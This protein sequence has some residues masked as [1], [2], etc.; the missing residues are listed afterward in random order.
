MSVDECERCGVKC[1]LIEHNERLQARAEGAT[2]L[3]VVNPMS[4]PDGVIKRIF[5]PD[6]CAKVGALARELF[7]SHDT[8][9][10][11]FIC[12]SFAADD[13]PDLRGFDGFE[14][15]QGQYQ[16]D[17][18]GSSS[19]ILYAKQVAKLGHI[20]PALPH[21]I[22]R[23]AGLMPFDTVV[24]HH[25][26]L[27]Q[28]QDNP[29]VVFDWHNDTAQE[30]DDTDRGSGKALLTVIHFVFCSTD[31]EGSAVQV[32]GKDPVVYSDVGDTMIFAAH[33]VHKSVAPVRGRCIKLAT[34]YTQKETLPVCLLQDRTSRFA[35]V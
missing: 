21:L 19:M 20:C 12:S 13:Q 7:E 1:L 11:R 29:G 16:S 28:G 4:T 33:C 5:E 23:H 10:G 22:R 31:Y 3:G 14:Q 2:A 26:L 27:L 8:D 32:Y 17:Q 25:T 6:L 15:V 24:G 35:L 34:T 9:T 30:N 18:Q